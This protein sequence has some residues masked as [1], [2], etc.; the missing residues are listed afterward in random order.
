M[1]EFEDLP[2]SEIATLIQV[3]RQA[4]DRSQADVAEYRD[5][6]VSARKRLS[7][8]RR[9]MNELLEIQTKRNKLRG[10]LDGDEEL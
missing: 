4:G 5:K 9:K 1:T 3:H 6:L 8:H 2:D 10:Y 7:V